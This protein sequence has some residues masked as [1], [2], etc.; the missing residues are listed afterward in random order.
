MQSCFKFL[1]LIFFNKCIWM[2]LELPPN[3]RHLTY[4]MACNAHEN[5]EYQYLK[6]CAYSTLFV[7][8]YLFKLCFRFDVKIN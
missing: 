4:K 1:S 7:L 8:Y 6:A 3:A 5:F 2:T